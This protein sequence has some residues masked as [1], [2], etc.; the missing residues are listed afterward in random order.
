MNNEPSIT[1]A[2][3]EK[4]LTNRLTGELQ[5]DL[6]DLCFPPPK[7]R[8]FHIELDSQDLPCSCETS[9]DDYLD[10]SEGHTIIEVIEVIK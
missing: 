6:L 2:E 10:V 4:I 8:T 3:L 7:P 9:L 5:E 1:K